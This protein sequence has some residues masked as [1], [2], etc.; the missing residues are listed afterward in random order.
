MPKSKILLVEDEVDL[1]KII[2]MN[3]EEEGYV[4]ETA[5]D[6]E[7]ALAK[8]SKT[9]PNL[10]ILD[11]MMPKVD[12]WEC[13]SQI[14]KNPKTKTLPV[15]I[16]TAKT[17]E[18]SK[19]FGFNL[20]ADDYVTKPFSFKELAARVSAVLRR[21]QISQRAT[22]KPGVEV[23]KIPVVRGAPGVDLINQKEIFYADAVHNYTRI[24]TYDSSRL[25]HF[26]LSELEKKLAD[27]FMRIHRSYIVNLNQIESIFS[28]SKSTYRI[29]LKDQNKTTLA[30]SR[31]KIKQLRARLGMQNPPTPP[32]RKGGNKGG[33]YIL[34]M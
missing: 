30:V 1:V 33:F 23:A 10:V 19:L 9:K 24:H 20:E 14:R 7:E 28:P 18:I 29:Q 6:G 17:E 13:L 26:S 25:T 22:G 8:I 5:H 4:V 11:I 2:K 15:I 16:L 3:L 12:G 31:S 27:F 32:F 34:Q 21:Y